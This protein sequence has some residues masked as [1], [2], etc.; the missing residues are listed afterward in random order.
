[1]NAPALLQEISVCRFI[2]IDAD[3]KDHYHAGVFHL[4]ENWSSEGISSMQAGTTSPRS[5]AQAPGRQSLDCVIVWPASVRIENSGAVS[6][7]P[8]RVSR[9]AWA[10]PQPER[11]H[12][13]RDCYLQKGLPLI[14]CHMGTF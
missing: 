14:C 13:P 7:T 12:Q 2:L 10:T 8:I 5:S 11:Q 4:L 3:P 6:P 9:C 1:M